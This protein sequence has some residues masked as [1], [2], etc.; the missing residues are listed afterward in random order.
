[1]DCIVSL[2][3][4]KGRINE[5]TLPKIIFRLLTQKTKYDYKVVLVLSEEEFGKEYKLP[6]E[7]SLLQNHPK[8]EVLWTYKNTKALK[9]LDPSMK[10]YSDLPIITL[11][12]DDLCTKN[13]IE[14]IMNFHKSNPNKI[15][16]TICGR[17]NN[18][19]RVAGLRLFPPN[20]LE[21]IPT[22]YFETYFKSLHDDEWNGIRAQ[23]KGTESI[24]LKD[25]VIENSS[26]CNQKCA[27]RKEYN[28][29]NFRSA[30]LKFK[31]EHP[32]YKL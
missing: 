29:F 19:I 12:D 25:R 22:E 11:D 14:T 10:K 20:S 8:F 17:Y 21:D 13:A 28:K 5:T 3:T 2:T 32:E 16:G 23:L 6:E 4:W 30:Y 1:M 31:K 27:F 9:K 18:I 26:F 15:I 7:L 24:K